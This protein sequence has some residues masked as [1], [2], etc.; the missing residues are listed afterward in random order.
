[1]QEYYI[2]DVQ[3]YRGDQLAIYLEDAPIKKVIVGEDDFIDPAA[4]DI[5]VLQGHRLVQVLVE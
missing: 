3:P 4:G 2:S 5:A 1:M